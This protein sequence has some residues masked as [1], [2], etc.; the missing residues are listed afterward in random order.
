MFFDVG[1][2]L[3]LQPKQPFYAMVSLIFFWGHGCI[4]CIGTCCVS[5]GEWLSWRYQAQ[6]H[7]GTNQNSLHCNLV[8]VLEHHQKTTPLMQNTIIYIFIYLFIYIF[9]LVCLFLLNAWVTVMIRIC[10]QFFLEGHGEKTIP[11]RYPNDTPKHN[12][13]ALGR[14][15]P[16]H[17]HTWTKHWH[18]KCFGA[19]YSHSIF[20]E[21]KQ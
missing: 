4:P 19:T 5:V 17:P 1:L 9:T 7:K 12:L 15:S 13:R 11:K 21:W 10:R 14:R 18:T 2:T 16:T 3:N 6:R 20:H 8:A